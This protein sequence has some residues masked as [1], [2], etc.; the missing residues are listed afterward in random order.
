M[1]LSGCSLLGKSLNL[2]KSQFL[3]IYNGSDGGSNTYL[4]HKLSVR[5][6]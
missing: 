5:P 4:L 3:C 6:T 2:S 1:S